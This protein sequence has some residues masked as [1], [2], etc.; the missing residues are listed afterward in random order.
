MESR[1]P[2][3]LIFEDYTVEELLQILTLMAKSKNYILGETYVTRAENIFEYRIA[4]KTR[5]YANAR[6]VRTMLEKSIGSLANRL[7]DASDNGITIS[8]AE[9]SILTGEDLSDYAKDKM[10]PDTGVIPKEQFSPLDKNLFEQYVQAKENIL[11][12][13]NDNK[14]FYRANEDALLYMQT[15]SGEGTGFLIS[16]QGHAITC[17]HVIEHT[18]SIK[19]RLHINGED[20]W[21]ECKVLET[22]PGLDIALIQLNGT[23]F[24]YM[25]LAGAGREIARDEPF[26][27]MGYPLGESLNDDYTSFQGNIASSNNQRDDYGERYLINSE[28]KGGNSGSPLIS[29]KD[30]T[31]IGILLGSYVVP[32]DKITEEIN[33]MRP[34]KYFWE[35]FTK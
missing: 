22:I 21:H 4:H 7:A 29:K 20:I 6:D 35:Q 27:L 14:K 25:K 1:V 15:N 10:I 23:D 16:P 11:Y 30:G 17:N 28:A 31:V 13:E 24:P 3:K 9:R 19:A 2:N 26:V 33:Y 34:I 12:D 8:D 18:D 5:G 32:N